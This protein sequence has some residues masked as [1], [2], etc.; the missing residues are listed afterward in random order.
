MRLTAVAHFE[1]TRLYWWRPLPMLLVMGVIFFLSSQSGDGFVRRFQDYDKILHAVA[2]GILAVSILIA[3]QPLRKRLPEIWLGL[4]TVIFCAAFGLLDEW[5][6]SHIPR[7][8]ATGWDILADTTG[9]VS[10]VGLW[11]LKSLL[12][13]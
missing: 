6:Q 1:R 7:R 4:A 10:V 5:Y 2:Y 11:F 9:A 13:F 3:V 12:R 8:I